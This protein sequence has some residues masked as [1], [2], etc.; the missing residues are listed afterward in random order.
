TDLDPRLQ[1]ARE[2]AH[3]DRGHVRLADAFRKR[4]SLTVLEAVRENACRE[5]LLGLR[6]MARGLDGERFVDTTV[7][8]AECDV[9]RVHRGGEGH[10]TKLA[11]ARPVLRV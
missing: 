9:D 8:V 1:R 3:A 5:I 4:D 7:D 2:I 6:G 10:C 11:T